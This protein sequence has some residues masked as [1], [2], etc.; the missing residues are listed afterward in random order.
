M[1]ATERSP[2]AWGRLARWVRSRRV[3]VHDLS[4][5]PTL[6]PGDR[7]RVDTLAYRAVLPQPGEL[8]VVRDPKEPERWLVKRVGE[9][10]ADPDGG[11]ERSVWLL[12]DQSEAGRD[13]RQFGAVP[14]PLIVG[15]VYA[16]YLPPERR[17]PL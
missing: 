16:R 9:P 3:E 2:S 1:P 14:L 15:R 5:V 12:S 6:L 10:R 11:E 7:L 17:G 8:V 13:S 4:M